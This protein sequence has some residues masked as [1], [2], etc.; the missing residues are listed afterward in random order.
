MAV[1]NELIVTLF[2]LV[3]TSLAI[4]YGFGVKAQRLPFSAEIGFSEQQLSFLRWWVKLALVAGVLLPIAL[5][6]QAWEQPSSLAFWRSYL[7]VVAVQLISERLFS[8]WLVSSVVVPIGFCYTA[9]RLWQLLNGFTW[10]SLSHLAL[11]GFIGVVLFWIA[12][13]AM[14]MTIAIPAISKRQ[15]LQE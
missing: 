11:V 12:N 10:L 15:G 2:I 8:Q 5:C 1:N 13:L 14:L 6:V 9:F 4:S 7:L 3:A